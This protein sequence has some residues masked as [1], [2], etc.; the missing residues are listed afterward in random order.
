MK[1]GKRKIKVL[2][3]FLVLFALLGFCN[4][5][6]A[7]KLEKNLSSD[8][9]VE[10]ITEAIKKL[11]SSSRGRLAAVKEL[12]NAGEYAIPYMLDAMADDTR[13]DELT[14][15]IWALP[16]IGRDAIRPLAAALQTKDVAIKA[17]I[18]KALGKI[19]YPQSLP[20][21]KYIVEKDDSA[22]LRSLAEQSIRQIDPV[23]L[24][25]PATELF[26]QLGEKYSSHAKS[27]APAINAEFANIWFWDSVN[28]RLERK[29]VDRNY[30]YKL[31]AERA[32]EWAMKA[33]PR[34]V[35]KL[36]I[37]S[38]NNTKVQNE[39]I[40]NEP[41]CTDL[42]VF[43]IPLNASLQEVVSAC[44]KCEIEVFD[45]L[46]DK[47]DFA[48]NLRN[49]ITITYDEWHISSAEKERALKLL[50]EDKIKS[51]D[52]IY[53]G[54][55]RVAYPAALVHLLGA[56]YPV[57][58]EH[59]DMYN[60][61]FMLDC[62]KLPDY[63]TAQ[64]ISRMQ[65]FFATFHQNEPRSFLISIR[66]NSFGSGGEKLNT[67]LARKYGSPLL[68]SHYGG[69]RL[70]YPKMVDVIEQGNALDPYPLGPVYVTRPFLVY[71]TSRSNYTGFGVCSI[72]VL[73]WNCANTK[74]L[75]ASRATREFEEREPQE[76]MPNVLNY[77]YM[78]TIEPLYNMYKKLLSASEEAEAKMVEKGKKG[79]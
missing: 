40:S 34:M 46:I 45:G 63:M 71:K 22:E 53:K 7:D 20:Y 38:E 30:F 10:I 43:G 28:Q 61:Q 58:E 21:L 8:P 23:A 5:A 1:A 36:Q 52:V 2:T 4:S 32:C 44:E 31:M 26:Y 47:K 18:I 11:S 67:I 69:S 12:R 79:F 13:R 54:K 77:V 75:L 6:M 60:S 68:H 64:G 49:A 55:E 39:K 14:N 78:P 24:T 16:Q 56:G 59:Y 73:E 27:L 3:E 72:D 50:E 42:K 65:V 57:L 70:I 62:R 19:G 15:I 51:F 74:V 66:F 48:K 17:E 41:N 25:V 37:P 33:D 9:K 29:E 76:R 35:D